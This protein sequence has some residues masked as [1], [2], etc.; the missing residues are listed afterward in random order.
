MKIER[1]RIIVE[2]ERNNLTEIL[3]NKRANIY[4]ISNKNNYAIVYC[5]KK[6][7]MNILN[8]FKQNNSIKE[9]Y[10]SSERLNSFIF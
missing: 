1:A 5:D 6:E 4:Y 10:I 9:A 7:E 2:F 3:T 8:L